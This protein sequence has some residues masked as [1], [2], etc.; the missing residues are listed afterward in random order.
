MN[1]LLILVRDA[2]LQVYFGEEMNDAE[3]EARRAE[4]VRARLLVA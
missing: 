3:C 4:L 2:N 1:E